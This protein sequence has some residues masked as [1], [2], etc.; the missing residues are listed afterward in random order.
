MKI[1]VS[2]IIVALLIDVKP[3]A[4]MNWRE[5]KSSPGNLG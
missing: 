3:T 4:Q 1:A 2:I 5:K